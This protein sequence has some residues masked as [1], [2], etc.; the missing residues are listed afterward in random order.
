[1]EKNL[2]RMIELV[3]QCF[4][5]YEDPDQLSM[6]E[7]V[8]AKLLQLH[9]ATLGETRNDDGPLAWTLVFPTTRSLMEAFLEGRICE[10]ELFEGTPE[11]GP[12]QA[13]Y[14]CSALVLPEQR[15]QGL[16]RRMVDASVTAIRRDHAITELFCWVFSGEGRVLAEAIARQQGLPLRFRMDTTR[17]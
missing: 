2:H 12:F 7:R 8:R 1:M 11:T 9:P 4:G 16:A 5:N 6:D 15:K 14:L 10:R 17:P 3:D 13:I